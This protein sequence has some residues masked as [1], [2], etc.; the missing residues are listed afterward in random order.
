[1]VDSKKD[2]F[3][4]HIPDFSRL[5]QEKF[6]IFRIT[7][8]IIAQF[9]ENPS[10]PYRLNFH[11]IIILVNG[12]ASQLIDGEVLNINAPTVLLIAR[13]KIHSFIPDRFA[14][15]WVILFTDEFLKT[16]SSNLF[17]Q[18]FQLSNIP[19]KSDG[20]LKKITS[21]TEM[22]FNCKGGK[23]TKRLVFIRHLLAAMLVVLEEMK[24]ELLMDEPFKESK[25]YNVFNS[26]LKLLENNYKQEHSVGFYTSNMHI[27]NRKLSEICKEILGKTTSQI[28]EERRIIE[29]KRL[30][31]YSK[32]NAQQIAY[33]LGFQDHSYFTKVFK[34]HTQKTPLRYRQTQLI[35]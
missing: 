21:I 14:K 26:F 28:I 29:A 4:F 32:F 15:G 13:E 22:M 3:V 35:E 11:Q 18:F 23:Y 8:K 33:E 27:S 30:L 31:L 6:Q 19:V 25:N 1:M 10:G 24:K 16:S 12:S 17:S 5:S 7:P 9:H 2:E 34:R 20:F